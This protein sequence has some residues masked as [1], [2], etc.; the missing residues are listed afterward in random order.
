MVLLAHR[1]IRLRPTS[2]FTVFH[3]RVFRDTPITLEPYIFF[4]YWQPA[5][6]MWYRRV[7]WDNH[8]KRDKE[9]IRRTDYRYDPGTVTEILLQLLPFY[10]AVACHLYT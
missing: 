8:L 5:V 6:N 1:N 2:R 4:G 9:R 7:S 10:T 3:G